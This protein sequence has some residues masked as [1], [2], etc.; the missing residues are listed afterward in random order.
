MF[1]KAIE[2]KKPLNSYRLIEIFNFFLNL[3]ELIEAI[4]NDECIML[5]K[6]ITAFPLSSSDR[7]MGCIDIWWNPH[8]SD[9]LML[10]AFLLRQHKVFILELSLSI[11]VT[12]VYCLLFEYWKLR[13]RLK[14]CELRVQIVD[15]TVI[16]T[17]I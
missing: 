3:V 11:R 6:D 7:L 15:C 10:T 8:D 12:C 5:A 14:F 1:V 13:I 17:T 4:A 2:I 9:L 16:T